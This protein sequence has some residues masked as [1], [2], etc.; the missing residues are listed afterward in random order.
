M[1]HSPRQGPAAARTGVACQPRPRLVRRAVEHVSSRARGADRGGDGR[2]PVDRPRRPRRPWR[3]TSPTARGSSSPWRSRS[4]GSAL[5]RCYSLASSPDCERRAQGD[6]QARARRA[7]L[8]LAERLASGSGDVLSVL[9]PEGRFVLDAGDGAAASSS[10]AGAGSRRSSRS[11]RRRSPRRGARVT[12]LYANRDARSVIFARRALAARADARR[13]PARRPPPRR[14]A[15]HARRGRRP[16]AGVASSARRSFY[17]CGPAP[18]MALVERGARGGRRPGGP[19][20]RRALRLHAARRT[21]PLP[22]RARPAPRRRTS[23]TS[24]CAARSTACPTS[25]GK[26]LLQTARD[27]GLDAPYSCEEGFCGCCASHLLEGRVV[28]AAD[29]ALSERGEEEGDDPR[30][31]VPPGDAALRV[32]VRR[33]LKHVLLWRSVSPAR[34]WGR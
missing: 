32:P 28:M 25:P 23:S 22:R 9:K 4:A 17:V 20:P 33:R 34:A 26:T 3:A 14:R 29:D 10:R 24:R 30:L 21:T 18:F 2:R 8:E 31:P 11:S 12:L 1:F 6:R 15:R 16:R 27:A 13:P 7:G 19:R 5:R